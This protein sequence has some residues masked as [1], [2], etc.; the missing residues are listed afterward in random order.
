MK[1]LCFVAAL[2]FGAAA[3]ASLFLFRE[4][5]VACS[6]LFTAWVAMYRTFE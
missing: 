6:A 2:L 4:H 5:S 3:V 1:T